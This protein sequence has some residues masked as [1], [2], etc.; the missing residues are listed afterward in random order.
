MEKQELIREGTAKKIYSTDN[1]D[2][3]ILSYK[4]DISA[5]KE[6]RKD[7]FPGKGIID[8]RISNRLFKVLEQKGLPTDFIE[9]IS[10]SET[11]VKNSEMIPLN[12]IVRNYSAGSFSRN[13]KVAEGTKLICPTVEFTRK[14]R[15]SGDPMING[16]YSLALG[17]ATEE[18]IEKIT[19][20]ALKINTILTEFFSGIGI[21]LIDFKMEFGRCKKDLIL[22]DEISPDTARLW[23]KQTHEKLDRDR[24]RKNLGNVADAY[25][26]VL[27]RMGLRED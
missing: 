2:I 15:L 25:R 24:F 23:D 18:E 13:M 5:D 26:E 8:N 14:D 3:L 10:P 7:S 9:E 21:D 27:V 22:S 6:N 16:Y 4:D 20:Y 17:I 1:S 11:A 12:V 19:R